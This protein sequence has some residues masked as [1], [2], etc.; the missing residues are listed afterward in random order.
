GELIEVSIRVAR[1][2]CALAG[3]DRDPARAIADGSAVAKFDALLSAQG[4]RLEE[5]LPVAPV[6]AA[7]AA[8]AE[9]YVE[10]ID[11]LE[12]GLA[13]LE[14]GAGRLRK[15]DSIDPAAGVVIEVPVGTYVRAG[16][17]LAVIHA[18]DE[19]R[20]ERAAPR[21][22]AAWRIVP[23][24]MERPPHVIA[25]VDSKGVTRFK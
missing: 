22:A 20:V 24:E 8:P 13:C 17:A 25:R 6:Q 11:A 7:L 14:L 23:H 12:V 18:R 19:E 2:M 1:E 3:V 5:G 15:E 10:A 9:G 4:G 16:D 21:L